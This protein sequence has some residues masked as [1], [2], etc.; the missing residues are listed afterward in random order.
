MLKKN[1]Y[2]RWTEPQLV[3]PEEIL[4][5]DQP[6]LTE[7]LIKKHFTETQRDFL[8]RR[9]P[10]YC[11]DMRLIQKEQLPEHFKRKGGK[12]DINDSA[13]IMAFIVQYYVRFREKKDAS[14][15][16]NLKSY[17]YRKVSQLME[18]LERLESQT[19]GLS[20]RGIVGR[21]RYLL[22]TMEDT[23][24]QL[25]RIGL[26]HYEELDIYNQREKFQLFGRKEKR[27]LFYV[28]KEGMFWF[29]EAVHA[30]HSCHS[31]ASRGSGSWI[32]VDYLSK[33]IA[34]LGVRNLYICAMTD[35]DPWGVF[36]AKQIRKKFQSE[37][38]NFRNVNLEILT[39]LDLYDPVILQTEKRYLL[40][41]HENPKDPVYQIVK[42]WIAAGGGINGEPY[43]IYSDHVNYDLAME[44]IGQWLKGNWT[45]KLSRFDISED[46]MKSA[47]RSMKRVAGDA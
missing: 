10:L 5:G 38:F 22:K 8:K 23:F 3:L 14:V 11:P 28:E 21:G 42:K 44:R 18:R 2:L 16:G 31:F 25:F 47:I 39:S 35:Y 9:F 40:A 19:T 43:G 41:G 4:R 15:R 17:W 6:Y 20:V 13:I 34:K 45:N 32:D 26:Y 27:H 36:I 37:L 30:Q 29:C 46:L 24:E 33:A 12:G 1:K 7:E